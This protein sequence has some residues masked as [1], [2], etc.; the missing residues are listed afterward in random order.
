[1]IEF[2]VGTTW[3]RAADGYAKVVERTLGSARV[4]S[5][6]AKLT[7]GMTTNPEKEKAILAYIDKE[8]RYTGIEFGQNAVVPHAV[9]ETLTRKYGDCKD[10][11]LL[12]VSM[13]RAAGIPAYMALLNSGRALGIAQDLPGTS[14]FNHAIVYVPGKP[15]LWIDPTDEYAQLG[16]IP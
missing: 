4:D 16:Q 15:E 11:A 12:M 7:K 6:V 5:L 2:A 8:V 3:Q 14:L 1:M 9:E 13:L 10:K